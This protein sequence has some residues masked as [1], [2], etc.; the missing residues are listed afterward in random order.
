MTTTKRTRRKF[1]SEFKAKVSIEAIKERDTLSDLSLKYGI[2]PVMISRWKEQFLANSVQVFA[3]N[4]PKEDIESIKDELYKRIGQL[5]VENQF[6]K[7]S[8]R[9]SGL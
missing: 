7:K 2:H 6:L 4:E 3:V 1:S 8:L 9:K 5:E